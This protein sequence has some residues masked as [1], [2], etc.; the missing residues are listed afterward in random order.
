MLNF[1]KTIQS[2]KSPTLSANINNVGLSLTGDGLMPLKDFEYDEKDLY[3]LE[4]C[5]LSLY[6]DE[7]LMLDSSALLSMF[8]QFLDH[9][10]LLPLY[11]L[12]MALLGRSD[13][14]DEVLR[15]N[16]LRNI[17]IHRI[18][19]SDKLISKISTQSEHIDINDFKEVTDKFHIILHEYW[20]SFVQTD[21][22]CKY[23]VDVLTGGQV[24]LGDI[25][26]CNGL[27]SYFMEFLDSEGCRSLV[28]FWLAVTNF[29]RCVEQF[30][31]T[32]TDYEQA[33]SDAI[34]IYEKYLSL[35][36]TCS[37]GFSDQVRITVEESICPADIHSQTVAT[38]GQ[39]FKSAVLVVLTFLRQRCLIPFL[40]S[41]HYVRYLSELIKAGNSYQS[42]S[43]DNESSSSSVSEYS[44]NSKRS[45]SS[46]LPYSAST[47]SLWR[48]RQQR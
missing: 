19:F 28:E 22:F 2:K 8:R 33:Q 21:M 40:S 43:Q 16:V 13:I 29:E 47:D 25:L 34:C 36:A 4:K 38:I 15:Q 1:W 30:K 32:S 26:L 31:N 14:E 35:Q 46:L 9:R 11:H 12:Y 37:L 5:R 45:M 42:L 6:F 3:G 7:A 10:N 23:Q 17:L 24:T 48:K 44:T 39:C 18:H 20:N 41:Q 27:L